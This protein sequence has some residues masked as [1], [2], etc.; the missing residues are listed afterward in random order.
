MPNKLYIYKL[1][2]IP[3]HMTDEGYVMWLDKHG[4]DGWKF[5]EKRPGNLDDG[6]DRALFV[7]E[8]NG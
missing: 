3:V 6:I 5:V 7:S 8:S 1:E 4:K 2:E